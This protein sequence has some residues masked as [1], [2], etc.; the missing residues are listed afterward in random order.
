MSKPYTA[1]D[2]FYHKLNMI[3]NGIVASSLI[4]FALVFLQ[5]QK[6]PQAP[7]VDEQLFDITKMGLIALCGG[8]LFLSNW[9]RPKLFEIVRVET[10]I[11]NK[12]S[13]Y[14]TQKVKQL[15]V[16]EAAAFF[17]LLGFYLLQEQIFSFMYVGVL[18]VFS[19]HR[20]SFARVSREI[21][22]SEDDLTDWSQNQESD[23]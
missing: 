13:L 20:P 1:W 23:N 12:L 15:V 2:R 7:I 4:P 17:A 3:F 6:E 11:E 22:V 19:M 10:S 18:I 16:I 9:L 8:I 5:N 14:L 21:N